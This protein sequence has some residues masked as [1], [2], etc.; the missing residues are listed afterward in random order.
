M[1][2]HPNP[3]MIFEWMINVAEKAIE[4]AESIENENRRE[5]SLKSCFADGSM[6]QP[7]NFM[8]SVKD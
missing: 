8:K 6:L 5:G 3:R 7:I 1:K 4:E 2:K